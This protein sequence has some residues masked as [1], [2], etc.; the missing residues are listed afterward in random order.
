MWWHTRINQISSFGRNGRVHLNRPMGVSSV[1]Y[2]QPS[3]APISGSNAGYTMF[4]GSV[5][6]TGYP[7][8]SP[9]T[10][11]HFPSRA[12]PCAIT[13]QLN[14][15]A[16]SIVVRNCHYALD[17]VP[18]QSI[19]RPKFFFFF[20]LSATDRS[21][22]VVGKGRVGYQRH[23]MARQYSQSSSRSTWEIP[24][25]D[26]FPGRASLHQFVTAGSSDWKMHPQQGRFL[27]ICQRN[28][29][30]RVRYPIY[31]IQVELPREAMLL[32]F[33]TAQ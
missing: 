9:V 2:W 22:E 28:R 10:P 30:W 23:R 33:Q 8:H 16:H 15:T 1:D 20:L 17:N 13:F 7:F 3:C 5:K 18:G 4:R 32:T 6:G 11:L 21:V 31:C 14:T 25:Q 29:P 26:H 12:S 19:I 27:S 24:S